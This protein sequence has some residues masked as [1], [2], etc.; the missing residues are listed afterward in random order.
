MN[1]FWCIISNN[2]S[3]TDDDEWIKFLQSKVWRWESW[4]LLERFKATQQS[5]LKSWFYYWNTKSNKIM[6]TVALIQLPCS[7]FTCDIRVTSSWEIKLNFIFSPILHYSAFLALWEFPTSWKSF[8]LVKSFHKG[9]LLLPFTNGSLISV[10]I[11]FKIRVVIK[12]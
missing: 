1:T 8:N 12:T 9:S 3:L 6:T 2:I 10:E 7:L 11:Q 4:G 5:A